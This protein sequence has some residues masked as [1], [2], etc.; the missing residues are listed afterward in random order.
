MQFKTEK[1]T[2]EDRRCFRLF[3]C[4]IAAAVVI[5]RTP[6]EYRNGENDYRAIQ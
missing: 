4:L 2:L 5:E 3:Y 6:V 1:I